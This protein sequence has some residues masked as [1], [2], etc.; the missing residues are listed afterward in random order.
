MLIMIIV[1]NGL[2]VGSME[3]M[4]GIIEAIRNENGS[5]KLLF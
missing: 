3:K 5:N 4:R 2:Q 1:I